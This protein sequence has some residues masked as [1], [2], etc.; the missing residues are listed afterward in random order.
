MNLTGRYTDKQE[1]VIIISFKEAIIDMAHGIKK[2]KID[3]TTNIIDEDIEYVSITGKKV[4]N[5]YKLTYEIKTINI[6]KF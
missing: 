6:D 5:K 4:A 2:F 3:R 1:E